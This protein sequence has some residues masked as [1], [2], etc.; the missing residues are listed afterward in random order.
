MKTLKI[1]EETHWL[2]AK[3][4]AEE[5]FKSFDDLIITAIGAYAIIKGHINDKQ[6][7]K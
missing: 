7:K 4:K 1:K 6:D 3:V 2:L 5:K